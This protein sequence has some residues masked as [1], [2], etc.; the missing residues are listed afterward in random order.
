MSSELLCG[1]AVKAAVYL[2]KGK[3]QRIAVFSRHLP[4]QHGL[5]LLQT[6]GHRQLQQCS[7]CLSQAAC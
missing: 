1:Y 2:A 7:V 6:D 5:Q 3:L 4:V